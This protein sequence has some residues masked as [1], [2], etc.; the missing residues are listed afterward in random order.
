M[1]LA[2]AKGCAEIND[3]VLAPGGGGAPGES[4]KE[5]KARTAISVAGSGHS[6]A[7][8]VKRSSWSSWPLKPH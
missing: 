2:A 7:S 5:S 1:C 6:Q 8:T 4:N 3:E